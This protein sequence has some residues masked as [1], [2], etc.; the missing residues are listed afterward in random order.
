MDERTISSKPIGS[1]MDLAFAVVVLASYLATFSSIKEASLTNI[2]LLIILGI[3]YVNIGIYGYSIA[4]HSSSNW[5]KVFYFVIQI[6]IG[7]LIVYLGGGIG[8]N[9]L[10]FLP[11]AG[12]SIVLLK[13]YWLYLVN[14]AL[15]ATF[16]SISMLLGTNLD[17]VWP[18]LIT[19]LAGQVFILVF[20]QMAV[21]ELRSR[22]EVERLVHELQ[23]A[24]E[25]LRYYAVQAEELAITKERNRMAREIHD[26]LGHYLTTIY[27]QIMA[28]RAIAGSNP[29][30][31]EDLFLKAQNVAQEAL[32]DI[33]QSVAA[34]R[35]SPEEAKPL[36]EQVRKVL[37]GCESLG[38]VGQLTVLGEVR[39]LP[40]AVHLTLYRAVQE[41]INNTCKHA[42][43]KHVQVCLDFSINHQVGLVIE[44][45]GQ[46]ALSTSGGFGLIGLRERVHQLRG[47]I[48]FQTD[49][50]KG[51]RIMIKVPV[52]NDPNFNRR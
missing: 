10:V 20:T 41:G 3:L 19:F 52:D 12:H 33:R 7:G 13:S 9:A 30:K 4:S 37:D 38:L 22:K 36:V 31:A 43:A 28:G 40:P 32:A 1:G 44:D 8:Y 17:N 6:P 49:I 42:H 23:T 51:F 26:G 21:D 25:Q 47:E 2:G 48:E 18:T 24:N 5:L 34:L 45:D 29:T 46:G 15:S 14:L 39:T 11:L 35:T 16:F 27:M 50:D